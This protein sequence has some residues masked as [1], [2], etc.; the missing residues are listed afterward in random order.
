M[1]YSVTAWLHSENNLT[2]IS[3]AVAA[4]GTGLSVPTI[5]RLIRRGLL[6]IDDRGAESNVY[7]SMQLRTPHPTSEGE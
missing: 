3:K 2:H 6:L 7:A 4:R 1:W 5:Y